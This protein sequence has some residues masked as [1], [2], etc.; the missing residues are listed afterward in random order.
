MA[1]FGVKGNSFSETYWV[2]AGSCQWQNE[3]PGCSQL[4]HRGAYEGRCRIP[5]PPATSPGARL[6]VGLSVTSG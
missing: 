4:M 2:L 5:P 3:G 6:L 1:G